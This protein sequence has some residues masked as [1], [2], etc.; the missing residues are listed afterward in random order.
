MFN[1]LKSLEYKYKQNCNKTKDL[2]KM[3]IKLYISKKN[4]NILK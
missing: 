4:L 2:N 1:K 3:L